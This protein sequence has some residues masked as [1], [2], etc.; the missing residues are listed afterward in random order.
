M[1]SFA[2]LPDQSIIYHADR[3]DIF[4]IHRAIGHKFCLSG[5]VPN[6]LLGYRKPDDVR[7]CCK[8]VID[9]VAR[10]GGYIMDAS[11]II[12]NDAKVENVRAMT[13]A[14]LDPGLTR[15]LYVSLGEPLDDRGRAWPG[16]SVPI[17]KAIMAIV[18]SIL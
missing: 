9:G 7:D 1:G 17:R 10:D 8:K 13:E 6:W 11:A 14:A 4:E 16:L 2:E 15:D 3:G 12:Q 18:E 5:G